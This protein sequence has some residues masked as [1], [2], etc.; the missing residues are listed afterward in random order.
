[1]SAAGPLNVGLRHACAGVG[2]EFLGQG[3]GRGLGAE[4]FDAELQCAGG[5][6]H[7]RAEVGE[8]DLGLRFGAGRGNEEKCGEGCA[9]NYSPKRGR[10]RRRGSQGCG[11]VFVGGGQSAGVFL[12]NYAAL[13]A[14][15]R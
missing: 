1:M 5:F 3:D 12:A 13:K 7:H 9:A 4:N 2:G 11:P 14:W 8:D 10:Q 6:V 15:S